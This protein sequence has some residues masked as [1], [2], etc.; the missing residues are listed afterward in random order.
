MEEEAEEEAMEAMSMIESVTIA[1]ASSSSSS[2]KKR[3]IDHRTLPRSEKKKF[4][5]HEAKHCIDRDYLGI[6]G[7]PTTPISNGK[8][9]YDVFRITRSRFQ[10]IMEDLCNSGDPF[11]LNTKDCFGN[12]VASVEARILLPLKCLAF[13]VPAKAFSDYFQVSITFGRE[14]VRHFWFKMREVYQGEYLRR[15]TEA[16]VKA[17]TRLHASVHNGAHGMLG[18]LDCMH[19]YWNKCPVAWQ[20][21]YRKGTGNLPSIV[22]EAACDHHLWFWHASYGYAGTLNDINIL[23]LS[24]LMEGFLD[25]SFEELEDYVTPY[26]I[27]DEEFNIL[28]FLVDGIYPT[29]SRFVKSIR[30]PVGNEEKNFSAFQESARKDIERAFGVLQSKFQYIHRPINLMELQGIA[31]MVSTCIILHNMCVSDRIMEGDVRAWYNPA[32]S[33]EEDEGEYIGDPAELQAM[34]ENRR[35]ERT[36][37]TLIENADDCVKNVLLRRSRFKE[38]NNKEEHGRLCAALMNLVKNKKIKKK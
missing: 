31:T 33:L 13:G 25:G 30:E 26:K 15:P 32:N 37:R 8:D 34:K 7:D 11:Y 18:S 4:R 27:G 16:D 14:C 35:K 28:Y 10:R 19:T 21:S 38:L 12:E 5:P 9:F 22:L 6:P 23:N 20:G 17:I 29:Y 2:Q 36:A 3:K 24:P 1:H